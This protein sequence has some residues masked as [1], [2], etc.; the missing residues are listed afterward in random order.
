MNK[1]QEKT[2]K[3]L[4]SAIKNNPNVLNKDVEDF[5][6]FGEKDYRMN[7]VHFYES[8]GLDLVSALDVVEVLVRAIVKQLRREAG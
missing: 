5:S 3:R 2:T 8:H 1:T 6:L 7:K 4:E